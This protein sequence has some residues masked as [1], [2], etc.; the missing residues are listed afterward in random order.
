M[1]SDDQLLAPRHPPVG[2][3]SVKHA[4]DSL[5]DS[6]KL[7]AHNMAR[8]DCNTNPASLFGLRSQ[9]ELPGMGQE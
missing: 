7:Y 6:Q 4:F 8:Y 3:M 5:N 1:S 9:L 2:Q